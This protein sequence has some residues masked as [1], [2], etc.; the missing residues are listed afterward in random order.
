MGV[1][2]EMR[3]P[4]R[5]QPKTGAGNKSL[6]RIRLLSFDFLGSAGVPPAQPRLRAAHPLTLAL[7]HEGRGDPLAVIH[8]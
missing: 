8:T 2:N 5:I 3:P 7:S 1:R 4:T 6:L